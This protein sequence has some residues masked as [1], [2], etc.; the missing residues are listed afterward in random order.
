M[1]RWQPKCAVV[2]AL[3]VGLAKYLW[4]TATSLRN[5]GLISTSFGQNIV[6]LSKTVGNSRVALPFL[7]ILAG[8][9]S[10]VWIVGAAAGLVAFIYAT[11]AVARGPHIVCSLHTIF[12]HKYQN[13]ADVL[14]GMDGPGGT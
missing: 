8:L 2:L 1:V 6:T 11:G 4:K 13:R 7:M 9:E 3:R 5:M 10:N 12:P 14:Y